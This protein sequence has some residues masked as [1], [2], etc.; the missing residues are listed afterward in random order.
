[1]LDFNTDHYFAFYELPVSFEPDL[2]ALKQ[3]FYA[4]SKQFH[5]DFFAQES[6]EIQMQVLELA[7]FNNKAYKTL[8]HFDRRMKYVLELRGLLEENEKYQLPPSFLMEMMEINEALME[9]QMEPD[10]EALQKTQ[11]EVAQIEAN[12]LAEVAN[13]LS[14]YQE[15]TT[16]ESELLKVKAYY[17]QKKYLTRIKE[18]IK[19]L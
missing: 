19:K 16:S 8:N 6:E 1:M 12:L 15:D 10:V 3:Q 7:T 11:E 9:L 4:Y 17:Y 18:S 14:D 13:I 2:D 5:P